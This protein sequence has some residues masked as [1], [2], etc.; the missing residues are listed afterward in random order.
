MTQIERMRCETPCGV[1]ELHVGG[2]KLAGVRLLGPRARAGGP[3]PASRAARRFA[4]A[5]ARCFWGAPSGIRAEELDLSACSAF[6]E[7]V[8]RE[9]MKVGFGRLVTYGELAARVGRPGA[10][11][12][13]GQ[14]V[15]RNHWPVFVPC[16][17]VVAAGGRPGGFSAGPE[18]KARLL[19]HEGWIVADGRLKEAHK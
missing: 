7:R 5:L 11:R 15:G 4:T 2:G 3:Q 19:A 12:A 1:V 13:V 10:A 18:W 8:Y 14:A 9:L 17:R 16:H 6:Q